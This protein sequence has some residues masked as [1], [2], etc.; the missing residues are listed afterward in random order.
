MRKKGGQIWVETVIYTLI[1]LVLIG[2]VLSFI[3]PKIQD[4]QDRLIIDQTVDLMSN[5]QGIIF[6][7]GD[8]PGNKRVIDIGIK[9]GN[10]IIDAQNNTITFEL[11]SKYQYSEIGS[12]IDL[13][14]ITAKT[15]KLGSANKI[16]LASNYE[17]YNLTY[18]G[19]EGEKTISQSATPYKLSIENKGT[20]GNKVI[21]LVIN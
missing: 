13:G 20:A 3:T 2:L 1:A 16:T 14:G 21:D 5:I 7:I 12:V 15:E 19:T 8:V 17:G 18:D 6:S 9:K 4:I 11:E 10:L